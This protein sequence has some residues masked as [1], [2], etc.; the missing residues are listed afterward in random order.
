MLACRCVGRTRVT[1]K[2]EASR[3]HSRLI[4][5]QQEPLLQFTFYKRFY[6]FLFFPLFFNL[7]T[8]QTR[9]ILKFG[10]LFHI[11]GLVA[12]KNCAM[13]GLVTDKRMCDNI[14]SC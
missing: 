7:R 11:W 5:K 8:I 1:R 9:K 4:T 6:C 2:Y 12:D 3:S 10:V 13:H 14:Q